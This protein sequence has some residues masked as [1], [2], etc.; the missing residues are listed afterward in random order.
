MLEENLPPWLSAIQLD[1]QLGLG[2]IN[3]PEIDDEESD[4]VEEENLEEI[5]NG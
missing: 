3:L 1:Y 2:E 5:K 4:E